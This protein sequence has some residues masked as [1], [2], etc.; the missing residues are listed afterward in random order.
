MSKPGPEPQAQL[1]GFVGDSLPALMRQ[2]T[3]GHEMT[4]KRQLW[5]PCYQWALDR[6]N[7]AD[8]ARMF[9]NYATTGIPS[10]FRLRD[11]PNFEPLFDIFLALPQWS[12][13]DYWPEWL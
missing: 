13:Y 12:S 3:K 7:P 11:D 4:T 5:E 8:T 10:C 1:V 6:G 2:A 9:A